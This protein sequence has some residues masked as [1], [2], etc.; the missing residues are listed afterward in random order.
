MEGGG[1]DGGVG[2]G[3]ESEGAGRRASL[4]ADQYEQSCIDYEK[5]RQKNG[6][7]QTHSGVC[8]TMEPGPM[9]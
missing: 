5:A 7:H 6:G 4:D 1:A 9:Y 2:D 8:P 3:D